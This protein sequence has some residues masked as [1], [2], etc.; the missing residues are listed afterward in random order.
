MTC[1]ILAALYPDPHSRIRIWA[2]FMLDEILVLID[3]W[4]DHLTEVYCALAAESFHFTGTLFG[5]DASV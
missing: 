4:P 2:S 5:V 3:E 1:P